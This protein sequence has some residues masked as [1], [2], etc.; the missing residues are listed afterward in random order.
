MVLGYAMRSNLF[1]VST[2][3]S[4]KDQKRFLQRQTLWEVEAKA[5]WPP[6]VQVRR[7]KAL[8]KLH[9]IFAKKLV[10]S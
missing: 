1:F 9:V 7:P 8:W 4:S 10:R 3:N 6:V 2:F 5:Q